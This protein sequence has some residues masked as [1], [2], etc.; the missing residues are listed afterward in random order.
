MT[1]RFAKGISKTKHKNRRYNNFDRKIA[2]WFNI[3]VRNRQI[4]SGTKRGNRMSMIVEDY[5]RFALENTVDSVVI[6]DLDSVILFVN[7]AF[8]TITG[9]TSEEA[10]GQKPRILKSPHTTLDT[11]KEMWSVI[12]AGGWWRGE[13][14]NLKKSGEQWHSFLSIS[15]IR[16]RDG[17]PVAYI[18]IARDITEMKRLEQRLYEMSLEAIFMLSLAAEAKDNITGSHLQRV[19][20]YSEAI[21][22]QLGLPE[23]EVAEIGYSSMM[24]DVGKLHVPDDILMKAGKLTAGEWQEMRKH[25]LEGVTILRDKSFYRMARDI[26]GNHHERW[27]GFGYPSGKKGEEI[28]LSSRIVSVAD[29]FDALTTARPYKDAW[30]EDAALTEV[31]AGKETFFDP[32]VVD[33]FEQLYKKGIISEI[34]R[35]YP[36]E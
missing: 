27:D 33:A 23:E 13:I 6:T 34:L 11:Y 3:Y 7:P 36:P 16:D 20:S 30:P 32:Q 2:L 15:Q 25:P 1:E 14:I 24:H 17:T 29:V 12:L 28:P 26:A 31:M 4:T 35:R 9:F 10:V 21:A 22:G 8:T 5:F 19:R 18:G